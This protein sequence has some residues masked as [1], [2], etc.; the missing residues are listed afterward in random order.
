MYVTE[1]D[2]H[3]CYCRSCFSREGGRVKWR[4]VSQKNWIDLGVGEDREKKI[5]TLTEKDWELVEN[6]PPTPPA[7]TPFTHCSF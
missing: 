4:W 5:V 7:A 1:F 3:C 6:T 2:L